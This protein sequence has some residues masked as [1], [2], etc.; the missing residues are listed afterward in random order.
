MLQPR[1]ALSVPTGVS[2]QREKR[3][4]SGERLQSGGCEQ[5]RV[6]ATIIEIA[7]T[8]ANAPS[9]IRNVNPSMDHVFAQLASRFNFGSQAA[10]QVSWCSLL[11]V[12]H[13]GAPFLAVR[14]KRILSF[15]NPLDQFVKFGIADLVLR[16]GRHRD[17][18]I[19]AF[20]AAE[21]GENSVS[22][23][24]TLKPYFQ[25]RGFTLAH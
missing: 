25:F 24:G 20:A 10:Q 19:G 1:Q 11:D 22:Y 6:G 9:M 13:F 21:A 2:Q 23:G 7:T 4:R 12:T 5:L 15:Q 17:G 16:A 18:T 8:A 14:V 3:T